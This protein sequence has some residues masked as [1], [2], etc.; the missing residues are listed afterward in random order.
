MPKTIISSVSPDRTIVM[1]NLVLSRFTRFTSVVGYVWCTAFYGLAR[2]GC[3]LY[4]LLPGSRATG[5]FARHVCALITFP[6]PA[7][8]AL[9]G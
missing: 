4:N 3:C 1:V 5:K 6:L 2:F 7:G 9:C 8:A